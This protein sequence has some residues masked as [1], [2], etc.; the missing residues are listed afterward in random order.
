MVAGSMWSSNSASPGPGG[1]VSDRQGTAHRHAGRCAARAII[2]SVVCSLGLVTKQARVL[3]E[4]SDGG[5]QAGRD[6]HGK[7][8]FKWS[9]GEFPSLRV[10][11][12]FAVMTQSCEGEH[13][14]G[15]VTERVTTRGFAPRHACARRVTR[16]GG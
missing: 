10:A 8:L 3:L 15:D 11:T 5:A 12:L 9:A 6:D 2:G 13:R 7:R 14:Q 1:Y 16:W 4:V